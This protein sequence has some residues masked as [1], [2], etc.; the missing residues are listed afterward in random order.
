MNE[1]IKQVASFWDGNLPRFMDSYGRIDTAELRPFTGS[2]PSVIEN[3]LKVEAEWRFEQDL[4]YRLS[5][6]DMKK[7]E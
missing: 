1:K 5:K 6:R 2:H 3:W 4:T 7:I